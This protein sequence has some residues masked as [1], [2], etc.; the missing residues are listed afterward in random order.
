M[1]H[2]PQEFWRSQLLALTARLDNVSFARDYRL[3]VI[4]DLSNLIHSS[5]NIWHFPL[6]TDLRL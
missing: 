6:E 4:K 5:V 2:G 1:G 3:F